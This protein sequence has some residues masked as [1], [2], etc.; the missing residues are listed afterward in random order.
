V[1]SSVLTTLG[2][3]ASPGNERGACLCRPLRLVLLRRGGVDRELE[4]RELV[5]RV[6]LPVGAYGPLL[7][8]KRLRISGLL[9]ASSGYLG[10]YVSTAF[11]CYKLVTNSVV[12]SG[13]AV[14]ISCT[15]I[16]PFC[17]NTGME[18]TQQRKARHR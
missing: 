5:V 7:L 4:L 3:V 11:R 10:A 8:R 14:T 1:L 6:A 2:V 12:V 9:W 16:L 18:I 17:Y 13:H 15:F